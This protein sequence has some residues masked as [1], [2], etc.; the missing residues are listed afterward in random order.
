MSLFPQDVAAAQG[1]HE[2]SAIGALNSL[3]L[4]PW[5]SVRQ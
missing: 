5:A 1:R 4:G 2:S 3:R